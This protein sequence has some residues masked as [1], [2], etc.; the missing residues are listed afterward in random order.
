M[1]TTLIVLAHPDKRSFNG[2]WAKA[3]ADAC[4]ALGHDVLW[5]DLYGM[6]FDPAEWAALHDVDNRFDT[7]L[8]RGK[9]ALLCVTTGSQ[10]AESAHDGKEG[11]VRMLL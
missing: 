1:T 6:G 9:K 3:T 11:D 7:G 4:R 8:L 2:A 10:A 5:S